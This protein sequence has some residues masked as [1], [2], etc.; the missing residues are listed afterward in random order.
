MISPEKLK[1]FD[2]FAKIAQ[3]YGD[4]SKLIVA[5]GFEKLPKVQSSAQSGHTAEREKRRLKTLR[6]NVT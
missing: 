5:T 3:E 6:P 2:T 4:L 1:D